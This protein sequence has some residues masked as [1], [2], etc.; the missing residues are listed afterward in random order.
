MSLIDLD[1]WGRE[2]KKMSRT[3]A[4][5]KIFKSVILFSSF[6]AAFFSFVLGY[7]VDIA[8]FEITDGAFKEFA[9]DIIIILINQPFAI[10]AFVL[11]TLINIRY[12]SEGAGW[13]INIMRGLGVVLVFFAIFVLGSIDVFGDLINKTPENLLY[14]LHFL[15]ISAPIFLFLYAVLVNRNKEYVIAGS[16]FVVSSIYLIVRLLLGFF[17]FNA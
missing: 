14:P 4:L 3:D 5:I 8:T 15:F 17:T 2:K 6:V 13:T 16:F 10:T 9:Q 7:F 12:K 1:L 11:L